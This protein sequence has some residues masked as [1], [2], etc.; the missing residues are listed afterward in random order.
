MRTARYLTNHSHSDRESNDQGTSICWLAGAGVGLRA[1]SHDWVQLR[2]M[3]RHD[4][5]HS[6]ELQAMT[7]YTVVTGRLYGTPWP[8]GRVRFPPAAQR[9][10]EWRWW[11]RGLGHNAAFRLAR[12]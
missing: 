2:C 1:V 3:A 11:R 8:S 6:A 9:L 10:V 12:R 4:W 5:V 7:G